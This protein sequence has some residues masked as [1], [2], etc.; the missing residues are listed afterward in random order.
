LAAGAVLA[1][2]VQ[3]VMALGS[4]LACSEG[5]FTITACYPGGN[6]YAIAPNYSA[7]HALVLCG[8]VGIAVV[9]A[10]TVLIARRALGTVARRLR[11]VF[12]RRP[13][14]PALD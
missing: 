11:W 6:G 3:G 5:G 9:F 10:G 7:G 12:G 4:A 8:W 13:A 14:D 1:A 2:I